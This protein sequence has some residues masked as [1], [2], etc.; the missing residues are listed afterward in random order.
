MMNK[1]PQIQ[2]CATLNTYGLFDIW[3]NEDTIVIYMDA[4]GLK[5]DNIDISVKDDRLYINANRTSDFEVE[6]QS[7]YSE[8]HCK[9]IKQSILL[10]A[11]VDVNSIS[12]AY[13]DGVIII[14]MGKMKQNNMVVKKIPVTLRVCCKHF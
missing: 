9:I 14:T 8:R 13:K 7:I 5:K 1:E 3:S 11:C 12:S 2:K 6:E 10:P 4:P